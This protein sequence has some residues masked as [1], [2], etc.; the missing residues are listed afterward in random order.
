MKHSSPRDQGA[1][2]KRAAPSRL[3]VGI[4]IGC[5]VVVLLAL[6]LPR[7]ASPGAGQTDAQRSRSES[8][9]EA[10]GAL[11]ARGT[12]GDV[13]R[14]LRS[15]SG[16]GSSIPPETV[17]AERAS[18][19]AR[20]RRQVAE[21]LARQQQVEVPAQVSR[22]FD[23]AEAGRW[24]EIKSLFNTLSADRESGRGTDSLDVL[25]PA[26]RDAYGVAE[27]AKA[28]P[29]Q[30]LLDYG[31]AVLSSLRPGMVYIAGS[32]AARFAPAVVGE[33]PGVDRPVI[34]PQ[35]SLA[36]ANQLAYQKLLHGDRL[37]ML[38]LEDARSAF[39][40]FAEEAQRR[41]LELRN[42]T[43]DGSA[44]E[45]ATGNPL[46]RSKVVSGPKAV[47]G[48]NE[49]M[50]QLLME[51][52]P[53]V[54]FA[55]EQSVAMPSLYSGAMPLGPLLE[56]SPGMAHDAATSARA[57][58]SLDYWRQTAERLDGGAGLPPDA[59]SRVAYSRMASAQ[60]EYLAQRALPA[61]AEQAFRLAQ[62]IAPASLDAAGQLSRFLMSHGR[63][64]EALG[65]LEEFRSHNTDQEFLVDELKKSLLPPPASAP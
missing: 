26:V 58:Q 38:S 57:A 53:G 62:E 28:W 18:A 45:P 4:I 27:I 25:W 22:F 65:V 33:A 39:A 37:S 5:T 19:F 40:S 50:L 12:G 10:G 14:L 17:I 49:K 15:R 48:L 8:G 42:Q 36:E 23:A 59:P 46:P 56:L 13:S 43:G 7:G 60:A 21:A 55:I 9:E 30:E 44:A 20:T 24:D 41:A 51:K 34:L 61:E 29:A 47:A 54:T 63:E 3:V 1:T 16:S 64:A 31:E 2:A 52:N 35:N 6:L 32:D 11:A